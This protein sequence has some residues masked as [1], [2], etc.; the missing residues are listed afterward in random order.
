M[1]NGNHIRATIASLNVSFRLSHV[2][3]ACVFGMTDF[4]ST[5]TRPLKYM[6]TT[7]E[8]REPLPTW[9]APQL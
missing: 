7:N 8:L 4:D 6:G 1:F 2:H 9:Q 3:F 5:C